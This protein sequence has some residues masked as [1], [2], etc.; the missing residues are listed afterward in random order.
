MFTQ[1]TQQRIGCGSDDFPR[2]G[3]VNTPAEWRG[4]VHP[5]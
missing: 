5:V 1:D 2:V 3:G 4:L